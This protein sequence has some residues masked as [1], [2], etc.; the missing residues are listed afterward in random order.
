MKEMP[1][2]YHRILMR[3]EQKEQRMLRRTS[4]APFAA[5][6]EKLRARIPYAVQYNLERAFE[7]AFSLL[8]SPEGKRFL[9]HTY[10]KRTLEENASRW[11]RP[12]SPSQ[13]RKALAQLNRSAGLTAAVENTAVGV[14]GA[15][16]GLLGIG[17]P[18]IPV[19]LAWLLRSLYQNSTRYGIP[20]TSP[21]EQVYLLLLLQGALSDGDARRSLSQ[22]ADRLGRALD[23]DWNVEYDLEVEMRAAAAL[24]SDR[25]LL[26][27]FIQ[28]L[29]IVGVVGG[30]ANLSLSG[31]VTR[32]GSIK[33]KKRFLERKV[34][35][36]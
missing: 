30:A 18:D 34:R 27:K 24:L 10:A 23:H 7:K 22:R 29:P 26:V 17:L 20:C 16:L 13:A 36:L 19:L 8:F 15:V 14:E 6:M 9:E 35:G 1:V 31:A 3:L 25:L 33:Y 2:S 21:A 5:P 32:Y 11:E 4:P 28:G 12:L